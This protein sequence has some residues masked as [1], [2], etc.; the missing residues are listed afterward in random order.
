MSKRIIDYDPILRKTT[1]HDYDSATDTTYIIETQDVSHI[2]ERNKRLRNDPD[3]KKLGIR[4]DIYHYASVPASI[5]VEWKTKHG[6]D[7]YSKDESEM[8][9]VEKLLSSPD[10]AYLRVVNRI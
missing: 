3:Y 4:E 2:L 9:K 1:Y 5:L 10:Y 7:G 6:V 8:R